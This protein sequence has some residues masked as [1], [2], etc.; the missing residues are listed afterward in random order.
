[1]TPAELELT[2]TELDV[3]RIWSEVLGVA[4]VGVDGA[5]ATSAAGF[6][7][8]SNV[9]VELGGPFAAKAVGDRSIDGAGA[10]GCSEP[11]LVTVSPRLVTKTKRWEW[12][13]LNLEPH[14]A[15][16]RLA[17]NRAFSVG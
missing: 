2:P 8:A 6:D 15:C 13:S 10:K 11:L 5:D 12:V 9:G 3:C 16:S 4:D 14:L 17:E 7:D 1:M